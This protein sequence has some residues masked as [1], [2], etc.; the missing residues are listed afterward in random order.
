MVLLLPA[1]DRDQAISLHLDAR[2][3]EID[4]LVGQAA[5]NPFQ[6]E[7]LNGLLL[8]LEY[9]LQSTPARDLPL[10]GAAA[11]VTA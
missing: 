7:G 6:L 10:E 1:D 5:S 3:A 8:R 9:L 11:S 4:A 2:Q